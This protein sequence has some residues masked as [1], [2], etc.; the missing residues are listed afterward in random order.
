MGK[1]DGRFQTGMLFVAVVTAVASLTAQ[2]FVA[3]NVFET[4][5]GVEDTNETT[6][7]VASEGYLQSQRRS[8]Y[9]A[10]IVAARSE[11]VRA[12]GIRQALEGGRTP[13]LNAR[14]F[15]RL[16][17]RCQVAVLEVTLLGPPEIV[18][19]ATA[20]ADQCAAL[21]HRAKAA[22]RRGLIAKPDGY[23]T[24]IHDLRERRWTSSRRQHLKYSAARLRTHRRHCRIGSVWATCRRY[25]D[26]AGF[27]ARCTLRL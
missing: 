13:E 3:W 2:G 5:E 20:I 11:T 18:S 19:Q 22:L 9:S 1:D 6:R 21:S 14:A 10:L 27:R 25:G 15:E 16:N 8:A 23:R 24:A 17:R 7:E 4:R 12:V 26:P